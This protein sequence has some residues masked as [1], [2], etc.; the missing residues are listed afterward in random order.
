ML[1][2]MRLPS[3]SQEGDR[4]DWGWGRGGWFLREA[5]TVQAREEPQGLPYT[6]GTLVRWVLLG[7]DPALPQHPKPWP[8][9]FSFVK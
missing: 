8:S 5:V 7:R 9:V 2:A 6:P 4:Q 1:P 3:L